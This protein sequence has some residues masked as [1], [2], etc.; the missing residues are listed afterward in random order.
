MMDE[1]VAEHN[2]II[3]KLCS[4]SE[5]VL[6]VLATPDAVVDLS[7]IQLLERANASLHEACSALQTLFGGQAPSSGASD[8]S[9]EDLG[10][11]RLFWK[12]YLPSFTA[13]SLLYGQSRSH[14]AK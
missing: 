13:F 2:M 7:A 12:T 8:S 4:L 10:F 5:A 9:D 14:D 6:E 1:A 3:G 11:H